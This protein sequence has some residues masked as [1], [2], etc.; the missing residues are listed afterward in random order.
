MYYSLLIY[1]WK[2]TGFPGGSVVKHLPPMQEMWIR[3]LGLEDPLEQ[4]VVTHYGVLARKIRWTE[5][6]G[7]LRSMGPKSQTLLQ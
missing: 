4:D 1:L 2:E 7:R 5:E 6:P 3:S